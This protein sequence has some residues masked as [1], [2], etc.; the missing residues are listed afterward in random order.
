MKD[1]ATTVLM[2]LL[3]FFAVFGVVYLIFGLS[4]PDFLLKSKPV[5][6]V[7]TVT[8]LF[9]PVVK[10]LHDLNW[11]GWCFSLIVCTQVLDLFFVN[12][13]KSTTGVR[14]VFEALSNFEQELLLVTMGFSFISAIFSFVLFFKRE[15]LALISMDQIL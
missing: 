9:F 2:S 3:L 5:I 14:V 12:D 10:R 4:Y 8:I 1:L 15:P 7:T 6:I 13:A 11:S